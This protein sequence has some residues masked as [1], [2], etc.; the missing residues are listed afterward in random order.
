MSSSSGA[1]ARSDYS[2][3]R[4]D[5]VGSLPLGDGSGEWSD[6]VNRLDKYLD[7]HER[8]ELGAEWAQQQQARLIA[9]DRSAR[10]WADSTVLLTATASKTWPESDDLIPPI[11]HYR[12]G[13]TRT[14]EARAKALSRALSG[15]RWRAVRVFGAGEDGFLHV[16]VGVYVDE[17]VD[18]DR[19]DRWVR[20]HVDN[21]PLAT[22]EAHDSGAVR[23]ERVG[24]DNDGVTGLE[25]YLSK[26]ALGLDTTGEREHGLGSAPIHR[27]RAGSV[28]R[29]VGA[30][31][32]RYGRTSRD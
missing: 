22:D 16:H 27:K 21:S 17:K 8:P 29:A 15:S 6:A 28:L 30:D 24:D 32:V 1:S 7:N 10:E 31:P 25:G 5:D 13:I 19:F 12:R 18:V 4:G 11:T 9:T 26:N 23:I 20:A 3:I 14:K 2:D